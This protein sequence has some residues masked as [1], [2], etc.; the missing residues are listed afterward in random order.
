M[1]IQKPQPIVREQNLSFKI[2]HQI[3]N[4]IRSNE[5]KI[6][7]KIPAERLLCEKF[8]VSR[9]VIREAIHILM[10]KGL[11]NAQKGD[12]TY[13]RNI[14]S[15][16][17]AEYLDLHLSLREIQIGIEEFIEIR[18][19]LEIPIA[20]LAA[21]RA[22]NDQIS[23]LGLIVDEM[24]KMQQNPE[25]FACKDLEFHIAI[26]RIAQNPFFEIILNPLFGSWLSEIRMTLEYDHATNEAIHFHQLIYERIRDH[27]RE[28]AGRAMEAHLEQSRQAALKVMN[29]KNH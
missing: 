4:M 14:E 7:E 6:G 24:N 5:L 29:K 9:T 12:G 18:R 3:E 19:V 2:A 21:E 11:L 16:D 15:T 25:D 17:V 27:D 28:G 22:N 23:E 8:Q 13:V 26:A 20:Q 10:A 1:P